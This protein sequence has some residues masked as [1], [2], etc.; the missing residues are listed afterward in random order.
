MGGAA[1]LYDPIAHRPL[2]TRFGQDVRVTILLWRALALWA[3]GYPE[4]ASADVD[5]ALKDAQEIDQASTLMYAMLNGSLIH[6]KRG[7]YVAANAL[8]NKGASLA[9]EKG[10]LYWKQNGMLYRGRLL[11]L[12]GNA[13][14]A[15]EMFT[16]GI[17]TEQS[18]GSSG[19]CRKVDRI[20]LWLMRSLVNSTR[21][22]ATSAKR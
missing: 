1:S 22:G 17:V 6:I 13:S 14:D 15:V 3:L 21:L 8:L 11:A 10:A 12:T 7:N 16:C 4:A 18:T 19:G 2:A 9:D 5:H 20:W